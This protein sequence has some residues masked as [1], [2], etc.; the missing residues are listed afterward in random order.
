MPRSTDSEQFSRL[1]QSLIY[2]FTNLPIYQLTSFVLPVP[3]FRA[4]QRLAVERR[5]DVE[6]VL[7][8]PARR[9]RLVLIRPHAPF[10]AV[11]HRIG[12]NAPQELELPA[13]RVVRGGDALDERVEIR[14]IVLASRFQIERADLS[15]VGGVLVL[16]D[17]DPHLTERTA[18]LGFT[19][20]LRRDL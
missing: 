2:Q 8:A 9:V 10:G 6:H 7:A 14:R 19:R 20:A 12:R 18:E 1:Y 11:G 15:G 17:R 13:R 16:V 4:V 5:V 3:V